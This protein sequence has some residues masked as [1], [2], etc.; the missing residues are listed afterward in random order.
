MLQVASPERPIGKA[1]LL[2]LLRRFTQSVRNDGGPPL[3]VVADMERAVRQAREQ[4]GAA[5]RVAARIEVALEGARRLGLIRPR[6]S[7]R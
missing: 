4:G 6:R 1:E 2:A 5:A 7:D 3:D